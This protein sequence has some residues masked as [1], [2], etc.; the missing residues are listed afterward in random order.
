MYTFDSQYG[1]HQ[2]LLV[3]QPDFD[4]H[5]RACAGYGLTAQFPLFHGAPEQLGDFRFRI[6]VI[7]NEEMPA[8]YTGQKSLDEVTKII[9]NR[10]NL[11]LAERG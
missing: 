11:M 6:I 1:V 3:V 10:V 2:V 8:Y 9:E 5:F 7:M 4:G